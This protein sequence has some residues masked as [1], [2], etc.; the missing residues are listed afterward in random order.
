[1]FDTNFRAKSKLGVEKSDMD[2]G[3]WGTP[4]PS[5]LLTPL[6]FFSMFSILFFPEGSRFLSNVVM[7]YMASHHR[8][9]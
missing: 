5:S 4:V 8:R 7:I 6:P 2:V 9:Q 1:L 3:R